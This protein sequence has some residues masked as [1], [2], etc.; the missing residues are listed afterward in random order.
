VGRVR[1]GPELMNYNTQTRYFRMTG[2]I[3]EIG[4]R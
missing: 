3:M 4:S 1:K 2:A